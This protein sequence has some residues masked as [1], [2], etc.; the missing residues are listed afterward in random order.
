MNNA[1][2]KPGFLR[3]LAWLLVIAC[4]LTNVPATVFAADAAPD[5]GAQDGTTETVPAT[6]ETVPATTETVPATT[7]TVPATTETVPE[8]TAASVSAGG[9][10]RTAAPVASGSGDGGA[11]EL[12]GYTRNL[13]IFSQNA[14]NLASDSTPVANA[15]SGYTLT[16]TAAY[17]IVIGDRDASYTD[18]ISAPVNADISVV[19][20][21]VTVGEGK[22]V[23]V[24]KVYG[25]ANRVIM[26]TQTR[27]G[28]DGNSQP[29]P[30]TSISTLTVEEYAKLTLTLADD[31]TI[32]ALNLGEDS[33]LVINTNGYTLTVGSI[34][35]LGN[36]TIN[37]GTVKCGTIDVQNLTVDG[38]TLDAGGSGTITADD[39]I[40]LNN[41]TVNNAALLGFNAS[42]YGTNTLT[43]TG[44]NSFS[45]V[46]T[47]GAGNGCA[48]VVSISGAA[49]STLETTFVSD[50]TITY[51][52]GSATL[53]PADSWPVAYRVSNNAIIGS[54]SKSGYTAGSS[55]TLPEYADQGYEY[56][57]WVN[58]E[59]AITAISSVLGN[60]ELT[61]KMTAGA[62][63]VTY[64]LGYTPSQYTND[65]YTTIEKTTTDSTSIGETIT[66]AA[67]SQGRFGYEFAGWEI[68]TGE[69]AGDIITGTTYA[70]S[71]ASVEEAGAGGYLLNLTAVW[72]P[73]QYKVRLQLDVTVD[74]AYVLISTTPDDADSWMTI[75][76]FAAE[77]AQY[78]SWDAVNKT[79]SFMDGNGNDKLISYDTETLA[80]YFEAI[81]GYPYLMDTREGE[82]ARR[83][84]TQWGTRTGTLVDEN[85]KYVYAE[86]S[87]LDGRG[88]ATLEEY[89]Q[90]L[91]QAPITLMSKWEVVDYTLTTDVGMNWTIYVD[92]DATD[93]IPAVMVTPD[94]NGQITVKQGYTITYVYPENTTDLGFT[95]WSLGLEK[96]G[97][98]EYGQIAVDAS[99][100]TGDLYERFSFVMPAGNVAAAY[101]RNDARSS[102]AGTKLLNPTYD[103]AWVDLS[104]GD[105]TFA[106]NVTY[107]GYTKSGFYHQKYVPS[108]TP[109]FYDEDKGQYFYAWD[110][111]QG[112]YVTT[113]NVA[114][115][116]QLTL[117]EG[118][119]VNLRECV[120]TATEGFTNEVSGTG[121]KGVE[122]MQVL[123]TLNVTSN[124][125][126]FDVINKKLTSAGADFASYG[127]IVL[128]TED[129]VAYT[130]HLVLH[131]ENSVNAITQDDFLDKGLYYTV[132]MENASGKTDGTVNLGTIVGGINA[133]F[134]EGITV[135]EIDNGFDFII[136]TAFNSV[137]VGSGVCLNAPN[138]KVI[139]ANSFSTSGTSRV[140]LKN[141]YATNRVLMYGS[142]YLRVYGDVI[143]GVGMVLMQ[144]SSSMVVDGSLVPRYQDYNIVDSTV[145]TTGYLVVKGNRCDVSRV[146]WKNGTLICNALVVGKE[147]NF[148]GGTIIA[149]QLMST[150]ATYPR[151][152][153]NSATGE[154]GFKESGDGTSYTSPARENGDNYPF[155]VHPQ[156]STGEFL[157]VIS[158]SA[159][160][161]L[162]GYYK[163]NLVDGEYRYDTSI[164]ATD[165]GN[166]VSQ[167]ISAVIDP[168]TGDLAATAGADV[169]SSAL[170]T[171]KA[172]AADYSGN[173]CVVLGNSTYS[174]DAGS[175]AV[176]KVEITGGSLWA[177]GNVT[178]RNDTTVS[179][180]TVT[181]G[182]TFGSKGN[183]TLSGG[184]V[185]ASQVGNAYT[186]TAPAG[187]GLLR[188]KTTTVSGG[189][190]K[191]NS[192]EPLILGAYTSASDGTES[193]TV[194][195][196]GT[197]I[198]T[199]G[200][201]IPAGTKLTHD[202]YVNYVD[203]NLFTS[204]DL[205]NPQ[206][207]RFEATWADGNTVLADAAWAITEEAVFQAPPKKNDAEAYGIWKLEVISGPEVAKIDENNAFLDGNGAVSTDA[208][209][210]DRLQIPLYAVS[211][212]NLL[213]IVDGVEYV[214]KV[215]AG[216]V[217]GEQV[218]LTISDENTVSIPAGHQVTLTV[219]NE[220]LA[221]DKTVVWYQD[222][223]GAVFNLLDDTSVTGN[224]VTFTM[225][226]NDVEA[227][228]TDEI[229]LDLYAYEIAVTAD[230]FR[231]EY[232]AN[233]PE[234]AFHYTG[235]IR[236][237]QT[238]L[239]DTQWFNADY[240]NGQSWYDGTHAVRPVIDGS[241]STSADSVNYYTYN[242]IWFTDGFNNM[243]SA[244]A[245]QNNRKVTLEH[246]LQAGADYDAGVKLAAGTAVELT[247]DGPNQVHLIEVPHGTSFKASGAD[248]S[249]VNNS[250]DSDV[251][252]FYPSESQTAYRNNALIGNWYGLAGTMEVENMR[253]ETRCINGGYFGYS[254][255]VD[256]NDDSVSITYRNVSFNHPAIWSCGGLGYN[257]SQVNFEGC[258][259]DMKGDEQYP[260][261][262]FTRCGDVNVT[263]STIF[264][265]DLGGYGT[266]GY[267]FFYGI[268]GSVN[269]NEGANVILTG[270]KSTAERT[271]LEAQA[272]SD[273]TATVYVNSGAALVT[274][275]HVRLTELVV[276]G[277][278]VEV[279]ATVD[280]SGAYTAGS[281][282][283]YLFCPEVT[284]ESGTLDAGGIVVAGFYA[285]NDYAADKNVLTEDNFYTKMAAGESIC[286]G[287]GYS[288]LVINGGEVNADFVG[289]DVNGKV[290]VNGG[291]LNASRIG[292][293]GGL[294]GY[295]LYIGQNVDYYEY[296][297]IPVGATVTINGG[298]VN[299]TDDG[300]LGGMKSTVNVTGGTVNLGENTTLGMTET[301]KATLEADAANQGGTVKNAVAVNVSGGLVTMT[302]GTNSGSISAPYGTVTVSGSDT[303]V[304][305]KD[306]TALN[307]GTITISDAHTGLSNPCG[308]LDKAHDQVGVKVELLE[309]EQVNIL[310]NAVVYA[311]NADSATKAG[312]LQVGT[313]EKPNAHLY[314]QNYNETGA[315]VEGENSK[316]Y[317]T[318]TF[319]ITYVLNDDALDP[320]TN[321][322]NNPTSYIY[323]STNADGDTQISL[324]DPTRYG[325]NF[326]GWYVMS[327]E[328]EVPLNGV[329]TT[330]LQTNYT[331]YAK[332]E[333][334]TVTFT[335]TIPA[336]VFGDNAAAE[337]E[338]LAGTNADGVFTF[339]ETFTVP[340]RGLIV[341]SGEG[342]LDFEKYLTNSYVIQQLQIRDTYLD[343]IVVVSGNDT[344]I[345]KAILDAYTAKV[346]AEGADA[347]L[348]LEAVRVAKNVVNLTLYAN[349]NTSGKPSSVSYNYTTAPQTVR[350]TFVRSSVD[351]D[352]TVAQAQGFVTAAGSLIAASAPGYTFHG[353]FV[354]EDGTGIM[355]AQETVITQDMPS[356]YYASWT[357]NTYTIQFNSDGGAITTTDAQP[358]GGE[359]AALN[360]TVV[361]DTVINGGMTIGSTGSQSLPYAWKEGYIFNGWTFEGANGT[362]IK[363][364]DTT[365]VLCKEVFGDALNTDA[366]ETT[367]ALTLTA[368]YTP[369][370]VSYDLNGGAWVNA[371][372]VDTTPAYGA[373]L[374]G[375][376]TATNG[377]IV[378]TSAA[379]FA[380]SHTYVDGDYRETLVRKGYTFAG[381]LDENGVEYY[382][383][384]KYENVAVTAK[385]TP[386]T[387]TLNLHS[388]TN[389][390][391]VYADYN[392]TGENKTGITV[393]VGQEVSADVAGVNVTNWPARSDWYAYNEGVEPTDE[394]AKRYLLGFTFDML[395][396]GNTD[397]ANTAGYA[398][399]NQYAEDITELLNSGAIHSKQE[400]STAGTVFG[401]P[402][403]AD[404]SDLVTGATSVPDYPDGSTIDMYAVYRERSLVFVEYVQKA[405]GTSKT[406]LYSAPWNTFSNYPFDASNGYP[407]L[408]NEAALNA[409]GYYLIGWRI[410]GTNYTDPAYT[411][412]ATYEANKETYK[413]KAETLGTYDIMVYTLYAAQ[414]EDTKAALTASTDPT[415]ASGSTYNY[416]LPG[417]IQEGKLRYE[418]ANLDGLT[419]VKKADLEKFDEDTANNTVAIQVTLTDTNGATYG[420]YDLE[421]AGA[422]NTIG[423][424]AVGAGWKVSMTLYHSSVMSQEV[425][426]PIDL[427]LTFD[428]DDNAAN[429]NP[430]SNQHV[431][432]EG[433]DV[434]LQPSE[435]EVTYVAQVPD[436]LTPTTWNGFDTTTK[437]Q[438]K[439]VAYGSATLAADQIPVIPGYSAGDWTNA[440]ET[441]ALGGALKLTADEAADGKVTL[442]TDYTINNH[443]LTADSKTLELW[444]VKAGS[445]NLTDAGLNVPYG[446]TVTFTGKS[447]ADA[448]FITLEIAGQEPVRL[449][450]YT[451]NTNT[452]TMPDADVH[453]IYQDTKVLYLENGNI[454]I[455]ASGYT[456]SGGAVELDEDWTGNYLI[457]QNA[458]DDASEA[459]AYTLSLSGDLTGQAINLGSLN[460]SSA[461]SIALDTTAKA[462]LTLGYEDTAASLTAKNVLV[463]YG[464]VLTMTNVDPDAKADVSLAP[465]AG[466]AVIG[467][468]GDKNGQIN[469][470]NLNL[471]MELTAP[472]AASGIGSGSQ[473]AGGDAVTIRDSA[474]TV[475][476]VEAAVQVYQG[477]WIGGNAVE[478]VTLTN[479]T[480][481]EHADSKTMI[482][483]K[484]VDGDTVTLTDSK[485]GTS[486]APVT[487]PVNAG[488]KLALTNAEVYQAGLRNQT[489]I[490]TDATG[491]IEVKDSTVQA[492]AQDAPALYTGTMK[493]YDAASDVMLGGT[494]I[495]EMSNGDV[496]ITD[497]SI[498]QDSSTHDHAGD[499]LLL[500]EI[501]DTNAGD[502]TVNSL[503]ADASV[504]VNAMEIGK[505]T[506]NGDTEI[507]LAGDVTVN[508]TVTIADGKTLTVDGGESTLTLTSVAD[509]EGTFVQENGKLDAGSAF[510]CAKLDVTLKNV[511][512]TAA[513]LVA[514]NLTLIGG[515]VTATGNVGSEGVEGGVTTVKLDGARVEAERV[516]ALGEQGK[517]F[518]FV[519][520]QNNYSL[521]ADTTLVRDHYRLAYNV[522]D[523]YTT[524]SLPATLR[525]ET[526]AGETTYLPRIP[527]APAY[528]GEGTS[529]FG[530][531]YL[532]DADG[533][534]VALSQTDVPGFD[535]RQSA[536]IV[537]NINWAEPAADDGTRTLNLYAHINVTAEA[538]IQ[539]GRTLDPAEFTGTGAAVSVTRADAWTAKFTVS[540]SLEDSTYQLA[541]DQ[542]FPAGTKLTLWLD[543][544][545]GIGSYYH[546]TCTGSET[547][548][549]LN[550]F[551]AIG[552]TGKAALTSTGDET[553]LYLAAQFPGVGTATDTAVKLQ[554]VTGTDATDLASVTYSLTDA[555]SASVTADADTVTVDWSGDG[556]MTAEKLFLV[557]EI[558][559][560]DIAYGAKVTLDDAAGT[561]IG[562]NQILFTLGDADTAIDG[563]V[564][565]WAIEG[566]DAGEYTV[567]WHLT[568]APAGNDNVMGGLLASATPV[569]HEVEAPVAPEMDI[570]SI[571]TDSRVLTA[572]TEN[573]VTITLASNGGVEA[574]A[575]VQ[576]AILASFG[577]TD[578][579]TCAVTGSDDAGYT[580]TVTF[581]ASAAPGTYRIC[582]SMDDPETGSANDNVYAA[583]ILEAAE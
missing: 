158:G 101:Y 396:P 178:F 501:T 215:T 254:N 6:T 443:S 334:K 557:A 216:P 498:T 265:H 190:I 186:L 528:T 427:K 532:L 473:S 82:T 340:Y 513:D 446:T 307:G 275:G 235:N 53:T 185:T 304:H 471:T 530:C 533:N 13:N 296:A 134:A 412:E 100:N 453:A 487:V 29:Y 319:S 338:G 118:M 355:L 556:A 370:T 475:K 400:A 403:D 163:A 384:P 278:T 483:P 209:A 213:K 535:K 549:A 567:T 387:Y 413:T 97:A 165:A 23:T 96:N 74:E 238:N 102:D 380:T 32:T 236:V 407:A 64:D 568:A 467:G 468:K 212:V 573:T 581:A 111:R 283:G 128:D 544:A 423:T 451:S 86:G 143:N 537:Q 310:N 559:G 541:L 184:E 89:E 75:A 363:A 38:A 80:E 521:S 367:V 476:Q 297:K 55:V 244:D 447:G 176:R 478:S 326:L 554:L 54:V 58:G 46:T 124:D 440:T 14:F 507:D 51:Q 373:P 218:E 445:S 202:V 221:K 458:D 356:D 539:A 245:V 83:Q 290:T 469:L 136:Y 327:G 508:G 168:A 293:R 325:Y 452:F 266:S 328:E 271:Y 454:S 167:V 506:A 133:R 494:Q 481:T 261:K 242:R 145:N 240:Y 16:G 127:N 503:A 71:Y 565:A 49:T 381:W 110:I 430:L 139:V 234:K 36:V 237:T 442:T 448:Q 211:N 378:S 294:L 560:G 435:Y 116:N 56:A 491:T 87:F 351:I 574:L 317:G 129:A 250:K 531:W 365:T 177:A 114:T 330:A 214:T 104:G 166:P 496:T 122:M 552:G 117:A 276:N 99:A 12:S 526:T 231:T 375:Y 230:G 35:G 206:S 343:S 460:I 155:L 152:V 41:A 147:F 450:K 312:S 93:N 69:N 70:V 203:G 322:A 316:I 580:A 547:V 195:P 364:D 295:T 578:D 45:T 414:V 368:D 151:Y 94:E 169:V 257:M 148:S 192:D 188:W 406:V 362:V 342:T 85:T 252:S 7:E 205:T 30:A 291:T 207:V 434:K 37:G 180:G 553:V 81:G 462:N 579:V 344:T 160:V 142:S 44:S 292:T 332:W 550:S 518:T 175:K 280:S 251:L 228:I 125:T 272:A 181:C 540:G 519:E 402:E 401:L 22:S 424:V 525:T 298:E 479:T 472:S 390:E 43:M 517:T 130:V 455:T 379:E 241:V 196:Q 287:T 73:K 436:A 502:L 156:S 170:E 115:A 267:P 576:S 138:K 353:W 8:T 331:V 201:N 84:F 198:I 229:T 354:N 269:L 239:D 197:L 286:D 248:G 126:V 416:T 352:K 113:N 369:V 417:S 243:S 444:T 421:T 349:R 486:D 497:T 210:Y 154:W 39:A 42:S 18:E 490:G 515:T 279:G 27:E 410:N 514:E 17:D 109:W 61:L 146:N 121:V 561:R 65:D 347:T 66:L 321:S 33:E 583:F 200:S 72:T 509:S 120:M 255:W 258:K 247:I 335:V 536:L 411:D 346:T 305:V 204:E 474:I 246:V 464:A 366:N 504:T 511:T 545:N 50:Y 470:D 320:A 382:T 282:D 2:K 119:T 15:A 173:E 62:V 566:L 301:Q 510:D 569:S 405:D 459:T 91:V 208:S 52:Q 571:S 465:A 348:N 57:G 21:S 157:Y 92:D 408:G 398:V 277:G 439:T 302:D 10:L 516:G 341:G 217:G 527:G 34:S 392:P 548:I 426:Y 336:S 67:P 315:V 88:T 433:L 306:M 570:M 582:F 563:T 9:K 386:N 189:T 164:T 577:E 24:R 4:L 194:I 323:G 466:S 359:S 431:L 174:S 534:K 264:Y 555:P 20:N 391:S 270:R 420:P 505:I 564:Y 153:F 162:L 172:A 429:D 193:G 308:G 562:R 422:G 522:S 575:E 495:V 273:S 233:N 318:Q 418:F 103:E 199:D 219:N 26:T 31:T 385:W 523:K 425:T 489:P 350:E 135:N 512:T 524:D 428:N 132:R 538:A 409:E 361:Y 253:I 260:G 123:A 520:L 76:D 108:M 383:I 395:D 140:Y 493:I 463:P 404:Y 441:I 345:D 256:H 546:Y 144:G 360:A 78:V 492:D 485:I 372:A 19:M 281:S 28:T 376:A 371:D 500:H 558:T 48:S 137:D 324:E 227:F 5:T 249:S 182:G 499:Y 11:I 333:P 419:V 77:K 224:A 374:A 161:N 59:D 393:K 299:V 339:N 529:R 461:N 268:L 572:G 285:P 222:G 289:G 68:T 106:K 79:L 225:P 388:G 449:D 1:I 98:W 309:A 313:V 107:R 259:F 223:T 399:Y 437:T 274:P 311:K 415:A 484:A 542:A 377:G 457:L 482:G 480:V 397:T 358:A 314:T 47:V 95:L 187:D 141:L 232:E 149:N 105:I 551:T 171:A 179:G 150:P 357:P 543:D 40:A 300:Y 456:Q 477:A 337:F 183:L 220:M 191:S 63:V 3:V 329:L 60:V 303:A 432:F 262:L 25:G 488:T 394:N 284:V 288:G 263:D 112:F 226:A 90:T 159:N 131:G 389:A 438:V